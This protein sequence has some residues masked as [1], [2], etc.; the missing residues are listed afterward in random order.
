MRIALAQ[1]NP[2]VGDVAGNLAQVLD[3]VEQ[4]RSAGAQAL[5]TCELALVGYPPRDLLLREGVVEACELAVQQIVQAAG[6]LWVIVGHPSRCAGG[7]RPLRNSV[8][9]CHAGKI[10]A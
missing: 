1:I 7:T 5:M 4:A 6:D 9:I 3:A 8:S 2:V 10:V